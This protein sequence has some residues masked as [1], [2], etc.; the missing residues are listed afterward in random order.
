MEKKFGWEDREKLETHCQRKFK[1]AEY[2]QGQA[3]IN[4]FALLRETHELKRSKPSF[5]ADS[6]AVAPSTLE[7]IQICLNQNE[8]MIEKKN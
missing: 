2:N 6:F 1:L 5:E 4:I 8:K 7:K 3:Y